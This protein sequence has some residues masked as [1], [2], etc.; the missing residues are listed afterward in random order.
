MREVEM[1]VQPWSDVQMISW[2]MSDYDSGEAMVVK[3][4]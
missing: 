3:R 4:R 1:E 2:M